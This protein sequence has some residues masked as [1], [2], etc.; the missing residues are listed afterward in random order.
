MR[1][2][3]L[4]ITAAFA[5][6]IWAAPYFY[7]STPEQL[8]L[9][10]LILFVAALLLRWEYC[11]HGLALSL[12]GFFLCGTFLAAAEHSFL[13][14][15]HIE[16]LARR[17]MFHPEQ[18]SQVIG[19]ARTSSVRRPGGEYIDLEL[20]VVRLAGRVLP[21]QGRIRFYYF[22]NDNRTPP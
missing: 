16:S 14:S 18:P 5:A 6:G 15:R 19:W 1:S 22:A 9:L 10:G 13:P 3:L 8:F 4:P 11:A 21:A 2:P 17:G 12:V 7:L 20:T